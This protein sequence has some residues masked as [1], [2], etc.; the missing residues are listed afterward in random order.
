VDPVLTQDKPNDPP[1]CTLG[2]DYTYDA[3]TRAITWI[4]AFP[5]DTQVSFDWYIDPN[6]GP[7]GQIPDNSSAMCVVTEW[8]GSTLDENFPP[9]TDKNTVIRLCDFAYGTCLDQ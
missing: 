5:T 2:V 8:Q 1:C 7:C 9:G 4:G 3:A 6:N